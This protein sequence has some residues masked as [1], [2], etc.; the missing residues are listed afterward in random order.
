MAGSGYL[1]G[2]LAQALGDL[3][4][5]IDSW[6]DQHTDYGAGLDLKVRKVTFSLDGEPWS[7]AR[8]VPAPH[9]E[10]GNMVVEVRFE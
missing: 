9:D 4:Q 1:Y 10:D 3:A 2:E 7:E 8:L 6:R 5:R